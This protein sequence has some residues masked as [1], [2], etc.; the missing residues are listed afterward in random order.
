LNRLSLWRSTEF[1]NVMSGAGDNF[2]QA[3]LESLEQDTDVEWRPRVPQWPAIGDTMATAIQTALVGQKSPKLALDE[4][5][6][7]VTQIMRS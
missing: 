4:A 5:Q 6:A 2:I 3:A 7:R 1:A